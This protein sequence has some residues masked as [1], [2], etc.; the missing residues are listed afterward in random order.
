MAKAVVTAVEDKKGKD[1]LALEIRELST[2][3]DYFVIC[4]AGSFVQAEAIADNIQE[5]MQEN[6][7]VLLHK[8]GYGKTGWILLDYGDV[9]AHIF[10]EEER[11]FY[12]L[13]QLWGDAPAI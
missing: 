13:E 12:N 11:R 2:I 7:H 10:Q 4:S 8:E 5:K 6:G 3:A 9:I 1:I